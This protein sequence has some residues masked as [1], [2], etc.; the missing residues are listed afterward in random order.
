ME[1]PL[2]AVHDRPHRYLLESDSSDEEGQGLYTTHE[3]GPSKSKSPTALSVN[4]IEFTGSWDAYD[5]VILGV[6]QAGRYL[7]KT[8]SGSKAG[9]GDVEIKAGGTALGNGRGVGKRLLLA[10]DE[11]GLETSLH[12]I[13]RALVNKAGGKSWYVH[14]LSSLD[15]KSRLRL[16][17]VRLAV[18]SY[19]PSMYIPDRPFT[20]PTAPIRYLAIN[21]DKVVTKEIKC[22]EPITSPN[23]VTGL[24]AAL[25]SRVRPLTSLP[26]RY[27]SNFADRLA[28][29]YHLQRVQD[30][31][32]LGTPPSTSILHPP[33]GPHQLSVPTIAIQ[34]GH[35]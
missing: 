27:T 16:M 19:L 34:R 15:V 32:S 12:T 31:G 1:D 33:L 30:T 13:A 25:L 9:K 2:S 3:S 24:A 4:E 21:G 8:F 14:E 17:G 20:L 29:F 35:A 5:E 6:A 7:S 26:M 23:Y 28:A 22:A 18:S 10:V 11:Q